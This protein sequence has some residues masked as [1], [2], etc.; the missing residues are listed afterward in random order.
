MWRARA[1]KRRGFIPAVDAKDGHA[2]HPHYRCVAG[3]RPCH[4][5]EISETRHGGDGAGLDP[6]RSGRTGR[7]AGDRG[8]HSS[9][10]NVLLAKQGKPGLEYLD[11]QGKTVPW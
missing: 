4:C 11:Y 5:G 1:T 9:P 10:V 2:I 3:P 6:H 7:A 8:Q